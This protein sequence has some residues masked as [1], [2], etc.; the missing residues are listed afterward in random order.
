MSP[1]AYHQP[2]DDLAGPL[3]REELHQRLVNHADL[4]LLGGE[5]DIAG[6]V[7][8]VFVLRNTDRRVLAL[9]FGPDKQDANEWGLTGWVPVPT[10]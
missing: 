3:T 10:V 1:N 5:Q 7:F 6:L 8:V 9:F 4:S 2:F